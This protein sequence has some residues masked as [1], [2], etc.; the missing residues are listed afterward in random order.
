MTLL[1]PRTIPNVITVARIAMAPAVFVLALADGFWPRALA[2]VLFAAAA[3]SDLW[4]GHLARKHGWVSDFG[5]LMDPLA[6]KLLLVATFVPF[7]IISHRAGPTGDLPY[8]GELPVWVLIVIFGREILVTVVR[9]VE[10]HRGRVIPAGPSGKYKAV[11][12]NFFS[13]AALLWYALQEAAE[14]RAWS[15]SAWNAWVEYLHGPVIGISL[16][17]ALLLTV[18]SMGVYFRAWR[19]LPEAGT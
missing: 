17:I 1:E 14:A 2:F 7:F 6:D 13:G 5:K 18:Y 4:D 10:A 16:L 9:Q 11:V 3:L 12:Q 19:K 15:G 8:W